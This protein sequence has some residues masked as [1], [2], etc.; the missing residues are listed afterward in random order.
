[1]NLRGNEWVRN[2]RGMVA[3]LLFDLTTTARANGGTDV[4]VRLS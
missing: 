3:A 2:L 4:E 1:M